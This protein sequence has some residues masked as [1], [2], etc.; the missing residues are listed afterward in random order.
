MTSEGFDIEISTTANVSGKVRVKW[1]QLV[2]LFMKGFLIELDGD[3]KMAVQ[4]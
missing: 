2:I 3:P 4:Q 1:F